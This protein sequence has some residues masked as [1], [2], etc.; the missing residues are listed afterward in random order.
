MVLRGDPMKRVL[1]LFLRVVLIGILVFFVFI[2]I[3]NIREPVLTAMYEITPPKPV[4][5]EIKPII[6]GPIQQHNQKDD[7]VLEET[8]V[9]VELVEEPLINP[10][11]FKLDN[12]GVDF[13]IGYMEIKFHEGLLAGQSAQFNVVS[14]DNLGPFVTKDA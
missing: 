2:P 5:I 3:K 8:S 13:S 9:V 1:S 11:I 6:I 7:R 10:Y 14:P 4:E 12:D